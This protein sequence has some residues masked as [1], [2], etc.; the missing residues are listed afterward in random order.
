MWFVLTSPRD[1]GPYAIAD[2]MTDAALIEES[3][4]RPEDFALIFDRHSD[5][6]YRYAARRLGSATAEDVVAE[7]FL[8]A[9]SKRAKYDLTRPDA[10][11]WLYGIATFAIREHRRAEVRRHRALSRL[12][13]DGVV[14]PFEERSAARMSAERM[15]P[16]LAA[17]L[18]R[19]S[20]AERDLLLLI[21]WAELTYEEAARALG[22]RV[23]T[24]RSRLHRIRKKVR[25]ALADT[26]TNEERTA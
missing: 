13:P 3:L 11:P 10:R 4:R 23:G 12:E 16:G 17:A 20:A 21:A 1:A 25:G 19:L 6:I 14:E 18:A 9:F 15:Q 5:E 8:T 24:V 22:V 7:T 26:T 2:E